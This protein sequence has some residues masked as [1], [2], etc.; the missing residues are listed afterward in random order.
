LAAPAWLR[1]IVLTTVVVASV[2]FLGATIRATATGAHTLL[3]RLVDDGVLGAEWR[4]LHPRFG[5]PVRIIDATGVIQLAI[6][7]ISGGQVQWLA[8]AYAVGLAVT[9]MLK[10]VALVRYRKLRPEKRAYRVPLN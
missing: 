3:A 7:L 9:V 10:A 5:T 2:V 4:E 8:R 6:V 1:A